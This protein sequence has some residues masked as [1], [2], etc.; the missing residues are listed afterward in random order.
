MILVVL[1]GIILSLGLMYRY[2]EI[3]NKN[4]SLITPSDAS[5]ERSLEQ[6]FNISSANVYV[7]IIL[8][9]ILSAFLYG[10]VEV[11]DMIG[12]IISSVA[13]CMLRYGMIIILK[14]YSD[15]MVDYHDNRR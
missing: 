1:S 10:Y 3:F 13:V 15:D 14:A 4:S 6:G 5:F 7:T 2:P 8:A 9:S 12:T 11:G